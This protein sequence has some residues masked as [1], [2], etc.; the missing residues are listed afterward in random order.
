VTVEELQATLGDSP[1]D[2]EAAAEV[3]GITVEELQAALPA[4]P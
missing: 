2:L 3:L 4:G 1:P